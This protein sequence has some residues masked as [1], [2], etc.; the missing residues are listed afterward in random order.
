MNT[1]KDEEQYNY[2]PDKDIIDIT[3]IIK[4]SENYLSSKESDEISENQKTQLTENL[5]EFIFI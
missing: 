2:K 1:Q 4:K 3:N 5:Y